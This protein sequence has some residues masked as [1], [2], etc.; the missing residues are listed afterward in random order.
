MVLIDLIK[1]TQTVRADNV[2]NTSVVDKT[3]QCEYNAI[4]E[5]HMDFGR[6]ISF[7]LLLVAAKFGGNTSLNILMIFLS[8]LI[9]F[10]GINIVRINNS[11]NK[12]KGEK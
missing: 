6:I 12:I 9:C 8:I 4:R 5:T 3:E 1:L 2:A 11:N 10:L 7:T